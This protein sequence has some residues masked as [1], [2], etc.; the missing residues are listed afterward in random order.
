MIGP[1]CDIPRRTVWIL[2][3]ADGEKYRLPVQADRKPTAGCDDCLRALNREGRQQRVWAVTNRS[4][5]PMSCSRPSITEASARQRQRFL[6][7]GPAKVLCGLTLLWF[8]AA[9]ARGACIV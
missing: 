5:S 1:W 2:N 4:N 9:G 3:L 7:V 8:R 6:G